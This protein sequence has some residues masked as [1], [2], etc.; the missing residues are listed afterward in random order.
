MIE[1]Y[2]DMWIIIN[3]NNNVVECIGSNVISDNICKIFWYFV[4]FIFFL[5]K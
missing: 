3:L 1:I 4:V 2:I 5:L